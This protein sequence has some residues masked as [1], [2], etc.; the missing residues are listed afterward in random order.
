MFVFSLS[1]F[2]NY[3]LLIPGTDS[4]LRSRFQGRHARLSV[5]EKRCVTNLITASEEAIVLKTLRRVCYLDKKLFH[6]VVAIEVS[7]LK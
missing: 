3:S 1:I 4:V 7:S 6:F 2:N 5:G